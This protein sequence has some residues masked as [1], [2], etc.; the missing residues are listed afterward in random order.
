MATKTEHT[1]S[2]DV[3]EPAATIEKIAEQSQRIITDFI[4]RRG[5][6]KA[7]EYDPLNIG[8]AFVEI[9]RKMMADPA[10]LARAQMDLWNSH[11]GLWQQTANRMIGQ[12]AKTLVE[13]DEDDNR[14]SDAAW[15]EHPVFDY[16][17]Q[18]Y[19]LTSKWVIDTVRETDGMEDETAR[20]AEFY[21][22]RFV[23]A[24]APTIFA[25]TTPQVLQETIDTQ[26]Q[27]LVNEL[28]TCWRTWS[29]A[30]DNL[31]SST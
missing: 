19:L 12:E 7:L 16:I 6:A 10:R 8:S 3:E 25:L 2:H 26:G 20:K 22:R 18:S 21:T 28:S 27:N 23:D 31:P 14:F 5:D 17:K 30:R 29:A 11:I 9:T 4:A 24:M 1:S 15:Q 13:A